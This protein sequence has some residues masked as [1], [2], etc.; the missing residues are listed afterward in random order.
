MLLVINILS[1]VILSF[2]GVSLFYSIY[3]YSLI[4]SYKKTIKGNVDK[5][6]IKVDSMVSY[7]SMDI[8][9]NCPNGYIT[10]LSNI[11][12]HSFK[13]TNKFKSEQEKENYLKKLILKYQNTSFYLVAKYEQNKIIDIK[14]SKSSKIKIFIETL[15]IFLLYVFY[16]YIIRTFF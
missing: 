12:N 4:H 7:V 11:Y 6:E 1:T 8:K 13:I 16:T 10:D 15:F 9:W 2:L 5:I 14:K 3:D